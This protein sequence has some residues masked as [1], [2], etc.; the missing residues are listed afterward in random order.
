MAKKF[1]PDICPYEQLKKHKGLAC[2]MVE[3]AAPHQR[4]PSTYGR[5]RTTTT[6][7]DLFNN[8]GAG[9]DCYCV[10]NGS[11]LENVLSGE[12]DG[13][14]TAYPSCFDRADQG[15]SYEQMVDNMKKFDEGRKLVITFIIFF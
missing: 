9:Q 14:F 13:N 3:D 5:F 8:Q 10:W 4:W 7:P 11:S 2:I 15:E 1:D 12:F 6:D